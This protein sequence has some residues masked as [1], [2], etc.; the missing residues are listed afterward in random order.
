MAAGWTMEIDV[1]II[2]KNSEK[3][4]R[5][6]LDSIY[7]NITVH[8]LLI[9]D[10]H[11]RDATL[12]IAQAYPRCKVIFD[13]G[14]RATARQRTLEMVDTPL[15]AFVDSD[16]VLGRDWFGEMMK[17]IDEQTGGAWGAVHRLGKEGIREKARQRFYRFSADRPG[18]LG[19]SRRGLRYGPHATLLRVE[20]L[21]GLQLPRDL[22]VLEDEYIRRT[23]LE[24]GFR[25]V[26]SPAAFCTHMREHP[27]GK[28]EQILFGR[29]ARRYKLA[30]VPFM[31]STLLLPLAKAFWILV[32][33]RNP[34]LAWRE[35]VLNVF[36]ASGWLAG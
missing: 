11:S 33:T 14:T 5:E 21:R 17:V 36:T 27:R 30:S 18:G 20:A 8:H 34:Q 6:C 12:Q 22:H 25:F 19:L 1:A 23:V 29:M 10:G 16:V 13:R 35:L 28:A 15:F 4:L 2:T 7:R 31:V 24:N 32:N 9:V 26:Y 3:Y